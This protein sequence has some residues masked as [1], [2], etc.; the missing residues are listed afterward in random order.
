MNTQTAAKRV[1]WFGL[2]VAL[3]AVGCVAFLAYVAFTLDNAALATVFTLVGAAVA[4]GGTK[5]H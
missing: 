1:S 5:I 3:P 4:Y 2:V